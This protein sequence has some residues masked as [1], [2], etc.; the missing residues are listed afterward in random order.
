MAASNGFRARCSSGLKPSAFSASM[1]RTLQPRN[2]SP[3]DFASPR[4]ALTN[5]V[6]VRTRLARARI[7]I[8]SACAC[9]LRCFT[10]YN[11]SGSIRASRASVCASSRSS[12]L[13][14]CP[15]SRTLRALAT[16][17]SCPNSLSRRLIQGECV[18]I[19]SAIRL[20][21]IGPKTSCNTFAFV[22]T[23][24][25]S[26]TWPASSTTQYQLLR[27]P[28]SNPMVSLCREIFL[29]CFATAVLVFFIA[30]LLYRLCFEH[31]DNLG[32]YSIPPET[33]LLIPSVLN[34]YDPICGGLVSNLMIQRLIAAVAV[35]VLIACC[36][37]F[38]YSQLL[39]KRA[40]FIVRTTYELSEE[41]RSHTVGEIRERFG[42][43]LQLDECRGSECGYKIVLSNRVLAALHL[44][45]FTEMESYFWT[46]DAV[47][48]RNMLDYTTTVNRRY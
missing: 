23:H 29:L 9:A 26:C 13:R 37:M 31:V 42:S 10:G 11:N 5:P 6:R 16:I 12:F 8:R 18:P 14:L 36:S 2:L 32:A 34:S 22:R 30:G 21:G 39:R 7:I 45:P 43:G 35:S 17:T 19:S 40:Q 27:S 3:Y 47:V 33:G 46:R 20:R 28:R 41:K 24:C 25:S 4:A 38:L 48:Y 1:L 44:V 15:I